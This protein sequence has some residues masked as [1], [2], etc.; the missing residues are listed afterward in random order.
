[1]IDLMTIGYERLTENSFCEALLKSKVSCLV[2]IRELP[3][4]RKRGFAK[5]ALSDLLEKKG[6]RYVHIP[7]LGSPR[8]V[9]HGYRNDGDWSRYTSRF[10]AYLKTQIEPLERLRCLVRIEKCCLFCYE[11]DYHFCHRSFVA[12]KIAKTMGETVRVWNLTGPVEGRVVRYEV[13]AA[14]AGTQCRQ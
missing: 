14:E 9:R 12:E 5:A 8:D 7:E 10:K 1:M 13:S 11:E 4:S 2:D 3:I 6:I